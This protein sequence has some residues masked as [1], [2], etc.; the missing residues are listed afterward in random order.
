MIIPYFDKNL[1]MANAFG[2]S[3][4]L[5]GL[6]IMPPLSKSLTDFYTWRGSLLI[7]SSIVFHTS[8]M[9]A[10]VR[11]H[12]PSSSVNE[13]SNS[14]S[15]DRDS[16]HRSYQR[17]S[18]S[19]DGI[20]CCET[21]QRS[22]LANLQVF[23]DQPMFLIHTCIFS[24]LGVSLLAW[25]IFLVPHAVDSN[26]PMDKA[27]FLSTIGG[28]GGIIGTLHAGQIIDRHWLTSSQAYFC[29]TIANILAVIGDFFAPSLPMKIVSSLVGGFSLFGRGALRLPMVNDLFDDSR[30]AVG[31]GASYFF[32]GLACLIGT[33]IPGKHYYLPSM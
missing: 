18:N 20:L 16:I 4:T 17:L 3:G 1:A 27:V 28:V 12:D 26:I 10:L 14:I 2:Q 23:I 22:I 32:Y 9:A 8:A 7:L 15:T 24:L 31:L 25:T 6:M 33:T 21:I 29:F 11:P 30:R 19:S 13:L 5:F